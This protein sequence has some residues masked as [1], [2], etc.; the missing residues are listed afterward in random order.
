MAA[1]GLESRRLARIARR[2]VTETGRLNGCRFA[3]PAPLYLSVG[4]RLLRYI[5]DSTDFY[6][7]SSKSYGESTKQCPEI[8][9]GVCSSDQIQRKGLTKAKSRLKARARAR[10][11]RAGAPNMYNE[12][13]V[14]SYMLY[15]FTALCSTCSKR[16]RG[17]RP[18]VRIIVRPAPQQ[19]RRRRAGGRPAFTASFTGF[20]VRAAL[21]SSG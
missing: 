19:P 13:S 2:D 14:L 1:R 16:V 9:S 21:T 8:P 11:A 18:L 5:H 15:V 12:A 20:K 7:Y 4:C 17:D 3:R 10:A 6:F